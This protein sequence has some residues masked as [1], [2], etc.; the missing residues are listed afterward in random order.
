MA[1]KADIVAAKARKQKMTLIVL[2]VLFVGI[3]AFQ[4]PKLMKQLK[5]SKSDTA[6]P[7]TTTPSTSGTSTTPSTSGTGTTGTAAPAALSGG[8]GP[9]AR[10]AGVILQPAGMPAA[11]RG[12]LWSLSQFKPKDPFV[13]QVKGPA[14]VAGS[15]PTSTGA[16]SSPSPTPAPTGTGA[17]T[18]T[19][20]GGVVTTP[21]TVSPALL[22][23][24]TLLVNGKIQQ[25]QLKQLFPKGLPTFV[26]LGV[27]KNFVK[28]GVAGGKFVGGGAVKL[29][30]GKPVTVMNTTTGQ[31]FVMKLTFTGAA[32][33][34]IAGFKPAAGQ[35]TTG[36]TQSTQ[37]QA[38]P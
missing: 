10:V 27:G 23:Y 4:G 1:R 16:G 3:A 20:T 19:G 21:T 29:E 15:T 17:G 5:G 26:L 6:A 30:I 13:Q 24:A 37:T 9:T 11:Q 33:E 12:Q 25:L 32:P 7:A 28:I 18:A 22:A 31:R 35:T 36:G 34:Q 8:S 14:A 38:T 2:G